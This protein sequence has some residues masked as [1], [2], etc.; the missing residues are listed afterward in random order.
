MFPSDAINY[1]SP[2]VFK[3]LGITGT[4]TGLLTT[5]IFGIVKTTT[6]FIWLLFLIDNVGRRKLFLI[7]A[8]GA[9]FSMY[10]VGAYVA[11]AKPSTNVTSSVTPA[12]GSAIAFLYIWT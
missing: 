12:G 1:Y 7:G 4:S 10:Y 2:T 9:A 11:I 8:A 3:S 6:T 5:G